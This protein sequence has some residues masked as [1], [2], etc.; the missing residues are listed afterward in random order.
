MV[1][2]KTLES[3]LDCKEVQPVHP[4]G[5]QSLVGHG[6]EV[7]TQDNSYKDFWS[8]LLCTP[9]PIPTPSPRIFPATSS[10]SA[11]PD[12]HSRFLHQRRHCALL[13]TPCPVTE[14]RRCLGAESQGARQAPR[15]SSSFKDP[16]PLLPIFPRLKTAVSHISSMQRWMLMYSP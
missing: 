16:G 5:D 10:P 8:S 7:K 4:K 6:K 13:G 11:F 12:T 9:P 15:S 2:E 3:S 14:P 1:L